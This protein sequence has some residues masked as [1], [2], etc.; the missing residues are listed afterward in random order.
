MN[1]NN[2]D[3]RGDIAVID[4]VIENLSHRVIEMEDTIHKNKSLIQDNT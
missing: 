1:M 3:S 2:T 4:N